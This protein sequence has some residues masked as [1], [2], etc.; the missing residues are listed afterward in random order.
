LDGRC[1]NGI[2]D[3]GEGDIDCGTDAPAPYSSGTVCPACGDNKRCVSDDGCAG[4]CIGGV[5]TGFESRSGAER[6]WWGMGVIVAMAGIVP[7]LILSQNERTLD[8][9]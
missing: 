5:W 7:V 6:E 1:F 2:V 3:D 4:E 9:K 8:Y